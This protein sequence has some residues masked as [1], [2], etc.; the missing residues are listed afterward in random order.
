MLSRR[1]LCLLALATTSI[2]APAADFKAEPGFERLDN[3]KD[4]AGWTGMTE[5]WSVVDG[6]IHLDAKKA[7][8]NIYHEKAHSASCVIRLEFRA[9][10][11]GDSGLYMYG[12]QFQVRDYLT[13]GPKRY[14]S[15]AK[16][17]GQWNLLEFDFSDSMAVVKL[18]S[19]VIEQAWKIG[20]DPKKGLGLQAE[21]GDFD[22]RNIVIR[23]KDKK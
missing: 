9:T 21:K 6:A 18:N 4:L 23:E 2:V 8:E 3:G 16:P 13:A 17:A 10:E 11:G 20:I 22:F 14:A 19:Q 5:G 12:K 7:K 15:F 1:F